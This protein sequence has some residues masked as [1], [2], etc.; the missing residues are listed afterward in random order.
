[1]SSS[2]IRVAVRP[3][4]LRDGEKC[5]QGF[6]L[7][8]KRI[9][10][11]NKTF[12][13]D[14]TFS[15]TSTADD[16]FASCSPI[17]ESVKNGTNG[18]V[19]VY[20]Q[21]G[22]GK[23]HTM[24]GS[25]T[26]HNGL[27]F[28]AIA[29]LLEH[30]SQRTVRGYRTALTLSMLEL[31]N[32]R[33][34]DM[35]SAD[36]SEIML[37]QGI[38]RRTEKVVLTDVSTAAMLVKK[39]LSKRQ[40][41][42]TSMNDRSSRS[43]V[44]I[45]LTLEEFPD[46]GDEI[47]AAQV[48]DT[49]AALDD[50]SLPSSTASVA[51]VSTLFLVD[52]AGSESV[53][54]S[55]VVGKAAA[56]AG[57]INKSLLAL[58]M[59]ILALTSKANEEG[60][61][62]VPYRD[63]KLTQLLQ[64]SIGGTAR[65]MLIACISC[66]GTNIDETQSTLEYASKAR[67]IRNVS[68]M[69]RDRL[70]CRVR[71]LEGEIQKLKNRLQEKITEKNGLFITKEE[72]E[73]CQE[74]YEENLV[75]KTAV[76]DLMKDKEQVEARHHI[77]ESTNAILRKVIGEKDLQIERIRFEFESMV[78]KIDSMATDLT[79]MHKETIGNVQTALT[80][81]TLTAHQTLVDWQVGART[82]DSALEVRH[83][84]IDAMCLRIQRS[85]AGLSAQCT[86]LVTAF[87]EASV[88]QEQRRQQKFLAQSEELVQQIQSWR[89]AAVKDATFFHDAAVSEAQA[90]T[91]SAASLAR[92]RCAAVGDLPAEVRTLVAE[93]HIAAVDAMTAAMP[94]PTLPEAVLDA[95]CDA[96]QTVVRGNRASVM[97]P[98]AKENAL[99]LSAAPSAQFLQHQQQ[100]RMSSSSLLPP[101][102]A[103]TLQ[104]QQ[105]RPTGAAAGSLLLLPPMTAR[106]TT[107]TLS[108][109]SNAA[110]AAAARKR[111]RTPT[112]SDDAARRSG[113]PV[114]RHA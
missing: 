99:R 34:S 45:M 106:A 24:I 89:S 114:Q 52:L 72:H 41:A 79:R 1:M 80:Q 98:L 22:S 104:Q 31:Y 27:A 77:G 8:G 108:E 59:V 71:S 107:N 44:I 95:F 3:R 56:E 16:V 70:S 51:A 113:K 26:E 7:V 68:N 49:A 37:I 43:H 62:H 23:T 50:A 65:T 21:T 12:D 100:Q 20:G 85:F 92:Q 103:R 53:K 4:P 76:E 13:P 81:H 28:K 30:V 29:N 39:A 5:M 15:P 91:A 111:T 90:L 58:K 64:D 74:A 75:L 94:G 78:G 42:V 6:Q 82:S 93:V 46:A 110:A 33:L 96:K 38:P 69:E 66:I 9:L 10:L 102:Q 73:S 105:Q 17:I 83:G 67:S 88:A 54:K 84:E 48:L 14:D 60:V 47:F 35:L 25:E 101:S 97:E 11:G 36:Q 112:R 40:V 19:M 57:T 32:E 2:N 18:T 63:S 55:Q 86:S 87:T 109:P 61:R